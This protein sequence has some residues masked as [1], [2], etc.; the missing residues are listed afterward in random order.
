MSDQ[1]QEQTGEITKIPIRLFC[2]RGKISTEEVHIYEYIYIYTT[3]LKKTIAQEE[4]INQLNKFLKIRKDL[5]HY[6]N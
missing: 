4:E 3:A 2:L 1:T 6:I 5:C